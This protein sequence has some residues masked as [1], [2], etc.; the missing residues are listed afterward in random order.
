MEATALD[1]SLPRRLERFGFAFVQ[2]V[3]SRAAARSIAAQL[4]TIRLHRDSDRDGATNISPSPDANGPASLAFSRLGLA[5]HTDGSAVP[6]PA[7]LVV[8]YI[9]HQAPRGGRALIADGAEILDAVLLRS[10]WM[11]ESLSACE[12]EFGAARFQ[13][14]IVSQHDIGERWSIRYRD[15]GELRGQTDRAAN[16]LDSF[17]DAVRTSTWELATQSGDLYIT[18]NR[19]CLHGRSP[20]A[21]S[22]SV[23]RFLVDAPNL[24]LGVALT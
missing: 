12:F 2:N 15:D 24:D 10:D 1:T 17:N 20:F 19:R 5:P 14:S 23:V 18:D 6:R 22:R 3:G 16:A 9:E 21:G 13:A 8:N 4:G 7:D 11:M